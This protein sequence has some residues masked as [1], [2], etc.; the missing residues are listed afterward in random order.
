LKRRV[1]LGC[2]S[3]GGGMRGYCAIGVEGIT[4]ARNAGSL[5]RILKVHVNQCA[6]SLTVPTRVS[7]M[8]R[9]GAST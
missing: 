3:N 7:V 1:N 5:F 6:A 2:S 4:Q 9:I 8:L